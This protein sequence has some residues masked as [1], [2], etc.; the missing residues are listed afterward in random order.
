M[1]I[2]VQKLLSGGVWEDF[3]EHEDP[4]TAKHIVLGLRRR[5]PDTIYRVVIEQD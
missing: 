5:D 2:W 3:E 1:T 4:M